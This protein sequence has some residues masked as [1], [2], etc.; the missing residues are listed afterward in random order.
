MFA[1][2]LSICLSGISFGQEVTGSIV[3]TVRDTNGAAVAGAT[4]TVSDPAKDNKVV[5]STTTNDSGDFS[6]P[7]LDS[8]VYSVTVE[9]PNFQK[10]VNTDIK[11]DVGARRKVDIEL[12]AGRIEDTVTV[13]ADSVAVNLKH[14]DIVDRDQRRPSS[15]DPDQQ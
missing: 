12:T 6:I 15:R 5:R 1:I 8:S 14:A 7:N 3:G 10:S 9:A 11:V 2:A 13:Q 4:V